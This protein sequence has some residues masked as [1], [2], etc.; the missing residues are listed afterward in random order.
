MPSRFEKDGALLCGLAN[1]FGFI[2]D[3]TE[4]NI[5]YKLPFNPLKDPKVYEDCVRHDWGITFSHSLEEQ[6]DDQIGKIIERQDPLKTAVLFRRLRRRTVFVCKRKKHPYRKG[7]DAKAV[8][9]FCDLLFFAE[10]WLEQ[11]TDHIVCFLRKFLRGIDFHCKREL[12]VHHAAH[13]VCGD[14]VEKQ[15]AFQRLMF[16]SIQNIKP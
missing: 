2:F 1:A 13:G 16:D 11:D 6:I 9:Q 4:Q 14:G 5:R 12:C 10:S 8:L 3:E 7:T 15:T